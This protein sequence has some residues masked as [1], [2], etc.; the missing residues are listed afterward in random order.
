MKNAH[1]NRAYILIGPSDLYVIISQTNICVYVVINAEEKKEGRD[2]SVLEK[3][4]Q[5]WV[6]WKV[7]LKWRQ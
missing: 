6:T 5:K 4:E 7:T 2:L 3:A 1:S